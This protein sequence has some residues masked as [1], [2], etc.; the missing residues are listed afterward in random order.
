[1]NDAFGQH[2]D[3]GMDKNPLWQPMRIHPESESFVEMWRYTLPDRIIVNDSGAY[4]YPPS[5]DPVYGDGYLFVLGVR[6][7]SPSG[8][9]GIDTVAEHDEERARRRAVVEKIERLWIEGGRYLL[10]G[11]FMDD[12]GLEVSVANVLAKV[13]RGESGVAVPVWN[14]TAQPVRFDV[15]VHLDALGL[16]PRGSVQASSLD[17]GS[18]LFQA[19]SGD[20]VEVTMTL[21]PHDIDVVVLESEDSPAE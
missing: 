11:R 7:L 18:T 16:E 10:H 21:P 19:V 1:M 12:V 15:R 14:T 2:M 6:G 9:R 4:S 20:V 3:Y 17:R 8:K 5:H 13:Y